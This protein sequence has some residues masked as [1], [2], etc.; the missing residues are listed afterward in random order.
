MPRRT[1]LMWRVHHNEENDTSQDAELQ[2]IGLVR[3]Q[4]DQE[5]QAGWVRRW[6]TVARGNPEGLKDIADA[7]NTARFEMFDT[8]PTSMLES[9]QRG[10]N[11]KR[12][13]Q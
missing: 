1:F 12:K 6:I 9:I 11:P 4:P 3:E 8:R 7:L 10:R 5:L 13:R 2:T